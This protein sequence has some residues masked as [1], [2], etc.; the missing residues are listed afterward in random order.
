MDIPLL[1]DK[2]DTEAANREA[3]R[4]FHALKGT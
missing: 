3:V 1:L 4:Q 2:Q